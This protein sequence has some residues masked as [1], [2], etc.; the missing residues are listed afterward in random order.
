MEEIKN[1]EGFDI[2]LLDIGKA[3]FY[4]NENGFIGLKYIGREIKRVHFSRMLPLKLPY[5]Y[6]SVMD[7]ENKEIG[8]IRSVDQLS[9]DQAEIVRCELSKRYYCPVISKITSVKEKMGYVYIDAEITGGTRNFAVKDVSRNIRQL[10]D[11][12]VIIFD[13]DGNRY[14]INHIE[15]MDEKSRRR[16]EPY[17]F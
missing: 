9:I 10:E 15:K 13:V 12:R 17:L 5:E 1:M 16:L 2:G 8:I 11:S 6:I 4:R 14:I 7:N 3:T